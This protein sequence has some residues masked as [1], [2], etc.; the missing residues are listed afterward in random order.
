M[1]KDAKSAP[2]PSSLDWKGNENRQQ[3]HAPQAAFAQATRE[4][5]EEL[6]GLIPARY[7]TWDQHADPSTA[8]TRD[9]KAFQTHTRW[10]GL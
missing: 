6:Q 3:W 7:E 8:S 5:R 1:E 9:L 2:P 10:G 4:E